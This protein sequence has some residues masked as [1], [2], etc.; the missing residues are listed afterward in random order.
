MVTVTTSVRLMTAEHED[1]GEVL[2]TRDTQLTYRGLQCVHSVLNRTAF[3]PKR[4]TVLLNHYSVMDSINIRTVNKS[5]SEI[6]LVPDALFGTKWR[7]R[8]CRLD[9]STQS[10]AF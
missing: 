4:T 8:R 2:V 5:G 7:G 6:P 1:T 10:Y 3:T 9:V